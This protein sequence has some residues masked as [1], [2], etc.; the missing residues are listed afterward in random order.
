MNNDFSDKKVLIIDD[1]LP[2]RQAL[3]RML[4]NFGFSEIEEAEDGDIALELVN[5]SI[6]EN[7]YDLIIC[8]IY[9]TKMSGNEFIKNIKK[10]PAYNK[11]PIVMISTESESSIILDCIA[12]G[13]VNYILK[14]FTP[15]T[16]LNK[17]KKALQI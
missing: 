1:S 14:P 13:A 11:V 3:S 6:Q 4:K 9:M 7:T 5:K 15:D 17:I 16:V 10:L 2:I 8:D 12:A